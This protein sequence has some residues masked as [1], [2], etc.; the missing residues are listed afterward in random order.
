M[1]Q[2]FVLKCLSPPTADHYV[3][4]VDDELRSLDW[5]AGALFA[6]NSGDAERRPPPEPIEV[7]TYLEK[8]P[9]VYPELTWS[10]IPLMTRRL[11]TALQSAG[12][13]TLQ[14]FATKLV[15]PEGSP[16]PPEDLY[17]AVNLIGLVAAAD[18]RKSLLNPDVSDRLISAD[19]LSLAVDPAKAR[20][21]LLFRLAENVSAGIDT[22][23]WLK[24]ER[25]AG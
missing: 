8:G 17:L 16:P 19:F 2:Y 18:L 11:V 12:I 20:G 9:H 22:L 15:A 1:P 21:L 10:P 13:D 5:Y 14:T 3:L 23:S 24:P 4:Q 6:A 7:R 25:W